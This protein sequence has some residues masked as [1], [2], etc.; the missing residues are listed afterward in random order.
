MQARKPTRHRTVND[1]AADE[2]NKNKRDGHRNVPEKG[3][4]VFDAFK[5]NK[6]HAKVSGYERQGREEHGDCCSRMVSLVPDSHIVSKVLFL[7]SDSPS[8]IIIMKLFVLADIVLNMRFERLLAEASICSSDWMMV[9][10]W[11][12]TSP[13]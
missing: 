8:A 12:S 7:H 4:A 1:V 3:I 5:V 13:R 6:V 11:S 9:K 10:Q 2:S